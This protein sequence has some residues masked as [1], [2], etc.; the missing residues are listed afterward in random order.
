MRVVALVALWIDCLLPSAI[1]EHQQLLALTPS[2]RY[3]Y[4]VDGYVMIYLLIAQ[5]SISV[6]LRQEAASPWL[7]FVPTIRYIYTVIIVTAD[8]VVYTL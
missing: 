1:G 3:T 8:H 7:T 4:Y 2:S 6:M 5:I